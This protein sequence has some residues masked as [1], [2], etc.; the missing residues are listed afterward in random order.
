MKKFILTAA[1]AATA[2]QSYAVYHAPYDYPRVYWD[3]NSTQTIFP[4]GNYARLITL[5]D[6]RLIA[7]AEAYNPNGIKVCYSSD[8][9]ETWTQ[10]EMI[11]P[12]PDKV[13]NCVPDVVQLSDGTIVVGYNPRP[14]EPY[15]E[16]RR[17]GIR[18]V[19]STDNGKTWSDP[20]FIYDASHLFIDGSWEPSF[21][22]MPDGELHCYFANE[23][24]YTTNGDQE[25][26]LCRSFDGGQTWGL[27]EKVMYRQG[28]RDG[29]PSAIITVNNEIVV[30][31]EDNGHQGYS[32][33]RATTGRCSV[34]QNWHECPVLGASSRRHMIFALDKDKVGLSA[35]PYLRRM[36]NDYTLASWQGDNPDSGQIDMFTAVGDK[37]AKNFRQVVMPFHRTNGATMWNSVNV[38]FDDRVF[39]LGSSGNIQLMRGR[40]VDHV[41]AAYGTPEINGSF[42]GEEW[43]FKK[44][45]QLIF[46]QASR[47]RSTHDFL[48]DDNYLY[49]IGYIT[50]NHQMTEGID[51]DG[52]FLSLDMDNEPSLYLD[53][54][55]FRFFFNIS[56][57]IEF[58]NVGTRNRWTKVAEVPDGV[59]SV[60]KRGTTYYLV[61]VAIPWKAL[62]VEKPDTEKAL[63]L[64]LQVNDIAPRGL[65]NDGIPEAEIKQPWTWAEFRLLPNPDHSGIGAPA[66]GIATNVADQPVEYF[67]LQGRCVI[68]PDNGIYIR[69][70]GSK[71]EKILCK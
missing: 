41:E 68:N 52:V 16:E 9:G 50:D 8:N 69:R 57:D 22:E 37:D 61:E 4:A 58:Y 3:I 13:N 45:A 26:S 66:D 71:V 18:C 28:H 49:Y 62:G 7:V 25:I 56:G 59:K 33:F 54:N 51:K 29:M 60:V 46:G 1:I 32:G 44:A 48:Y 12:N 43:T 14:R 35:A 20:I 36:R 21:L 40:V 38:G 55:Q 70:Q 6:G 24:P 63:R 11:A 17:F 15:S 67:D 39:A 53:G 2:L 19:R 5:Q 27:A 10:P 47:M 30:I 23:G 65:R 42:T 31:V 64:N 34:E